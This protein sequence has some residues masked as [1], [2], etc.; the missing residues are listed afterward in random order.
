M[1]GGKINMQ[2]SLLKDMVIVIEECNE[3][4]TQTVGLKS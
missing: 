4:D 3:D 1:L 2:G